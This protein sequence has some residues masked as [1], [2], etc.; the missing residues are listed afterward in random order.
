M[1]PG[2]TVLPAAAAGAELTVVKD[3]LVGSSAEN[4]RKTLDIM[5][6]YQPQIR[7]TTAA[8]VLASL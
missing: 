5:G 6:L 4:H 7:V 3:A 8:E 2:V 1:K